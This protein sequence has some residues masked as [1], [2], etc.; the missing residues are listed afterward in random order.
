MKPRRGKRAP[1]QWLRV[2]L[3]LD[4]VRTCPLAACPME[5]PPHGRT[6]YEEWAAFQWTTW[7]TLLLAD[8]SKQWVGMWIGLCV[9]R[10]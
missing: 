7:V 8:E 9:L 6:F 1:E 2:I 10:D 5:R 3:D 4:V